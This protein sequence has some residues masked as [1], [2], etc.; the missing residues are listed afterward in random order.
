MRPDGT[1]ARERTF[2]RAL[3]HRNPVST[4]FSQ[5]LLGL[6][7]MLVASPG[8]GPRA[9]PIQRI[10][11]P[12]SPNPVGSGARALG[13]GGAFIAV[14]DD[15]TA[16]SWNPGGL[17]QLERPEVSVVG[18]GFVREEENSFGTH[19]EA[20]GDERTTATR[21]NYLSAAYPFTFWGRNMIV[22]LNY[23]GLYNFDRDWSLLFIQEVTDLSVDQQV[24]YRQDGDLYALGLAYA[25]QITPTF[26]LGLTLNIWDDEFLDDEWK[27][28]NH[29]YGSGTYRGERFLFDIL[30]VDRYSFSGI[31]VNL[32]FLWYVTPKLTLGAVLKSPF[33]ADLDHESS[34]SSSMIF[35]EDP[36]RNSSTHTTTRSKEKLEMPMSYGVGL[37]YRFSDAFTVACDLYRT[38]WDDF[39]LT[40]AHG[41]KTSPVT[42]ESVDESDIRPTVQVRLGAEYLIIGKEEVVVPLRGGVFYDPA[43]AK[44]SPDA[45]FG[46]SLGTGVAW[47]RAI[48]D[49]AYQYRYGKDVGTSLLRDLQF[50]QDVR[51]QTVYASLIWHF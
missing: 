44:G 4:V 10:E 9:Q 39:V 28:V 24:D 16:A 25:I 13:M 7:L 26:S 34:F 48:F 46:F 32:G 41:N 37:A 23:Q 3:I 1:S 12:S 33:E 31:N 11:I 15:A 42:G 8:E 29:Q 14:A 17:I 40:D 19:P 21:L 18:E 43:P 20:S 30:T 6:V 45:Y 49:V 47:G 27:A 50:S 2:G 36:A 22:S 51:E 38:E 5:I 35:P